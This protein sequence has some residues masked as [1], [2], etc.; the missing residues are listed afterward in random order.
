MKNSVSNQYIA[1]IRESFMFASWC[2]NFPK[3][4]NHKLK[5]AIKYNYA[6]W[7]IIEDCVMNINYDIN[8]YFENFFKKLKF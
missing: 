1:F 2:F 8:S 3:P 7:A 4:A 6:G 5:I